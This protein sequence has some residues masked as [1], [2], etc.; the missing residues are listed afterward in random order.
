MAELLYKDEVY[1]IVGAAMDV[2]NELGAGFLESVY[3]EAMELELGDRGIPFNSL[4]PLRIKFK[5]RVL[6]KTFCADLICFGAV[7]VELK[8]M[9]QITNRGRAGAQLPE[10]DWPARRGHHQL[11][12]SRPIGLDQNRPL[13]LHSA[14]PFIRVHSCRFVS[15]RG[16]HFQ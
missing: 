16:P 14:F 7:L 11:R 6:K 10:G 2:Y 8:A 5:E 13:I 15:I 4:V 9:D 1:A 12:R 3:Q